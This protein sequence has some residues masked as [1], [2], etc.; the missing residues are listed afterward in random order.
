MRRV[1]VLS[2]GAVAAMALAA[3]YPPHVHHQASMPLKAI[4][5][6]DCPDTQGDLSLKSQASDGK[7]CAYA[8]N[9]GTEVSLQLMAISGSDSRTA[10]SPLEAD[11][12]SE[13]SSANVAAASSG[14]AANSVGD[15]DRVDIDLPG[16]HIHTNGGAA[17]IDTAG[18]KI[19]A[20]NA[21]AH[22][23]AHEASSVKVDGEGHSKGVT[24]DAGE[25]GA[26][27]HVNEGGA[28]VHQSFILA[29]D[30]AGPHGYKFVGYEA[31]GPIGGP[32]AVVS[33]KAK[34][35]DH[36]DLRRDMRA[37]LRRNVGG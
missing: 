29:S 26:E 12:K 19:N 21:G 25:K 8:D 15:K 4:A 33:V 16:V 22:I 36:D 35:E 30:V 2:S 24:I 18:V 1:V 10:L 32:L 23:D 5:R 13:L 14:Q 20:D 3:C 7:S 9:D 31:R 11:L 27:I 6:L 37:L 34:D 28:G 17:S